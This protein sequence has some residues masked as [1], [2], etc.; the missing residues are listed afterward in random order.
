MLK[1][2]PK[3]F[4]IRAFLFFSMLL[5]L[6]CDAKKK[7]LNT[8]NKPI[9]ENLITATESWAGD[10]Y[11]YPK[12]Q[13][14]MTLLRIKVPV[15]YRTPVHIHPQPGVAFVAKGRLECVVKANKTLIAET[16]DSFATNFGDV[17]HYCENIGDDEV[18]IFVAY[19]GAEGKVLTIP[20]DGNNNSN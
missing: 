8:Y 12:G 19:A 1:S 6:G 9:I 18:L 16:G 14:Q 20:L 5:L 11:S 4:L 15:G 10:V 17:P 3:T 13:A 2:C 7:S